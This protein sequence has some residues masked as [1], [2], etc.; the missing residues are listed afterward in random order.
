MIPPRA[1]IAA[2]TARART[3]MR[4]I[5]AEAARPVRTLFRPTDE[6]GVRSNG[7]RAC[8]SI[9]MSEILHAGIVCGAQQCPRGRRAAD[10]P[11]STDVKTFQCA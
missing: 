9:V 1:P 4:L 2:R 8:I 7:P 11:N 6:R 5:V 3:Q 10:R